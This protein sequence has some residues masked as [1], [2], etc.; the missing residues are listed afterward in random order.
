M[1]FNIAFRFFRQYEEK[2]LKDVQEKEGKR[3]EFR[4][5]QSRL[6]NQVWFHIT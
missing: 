4:K 5:E 3:L 2:Q 1:D 6:K